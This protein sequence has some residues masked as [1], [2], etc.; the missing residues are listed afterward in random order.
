MKSP[1]FEELTERDTELIENLFP[2]YLFYDTLLNGDREF[3]CSHCRQR[4]IKSHI[5]RTS[6]YEDREL[7][8]VRHGDLRCCPLCGA[9]T[10]VKN[11][12]KSKQRK[13]LWCREKVVVIHAVNHDRVEARCYFAEKDYEYSPAP[14]TELIEKSRYLL[15]PV[16]DAYFAKLVEEKYDLSPAGI[17]EFLDL[18]NVDYE[19]LAEGCHY[20][21]ELPKRVEERV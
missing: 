17:I 14:K 16:E 18:L 8:H 5:A 1:E 10:T 12:G 3:Q 2:H 13:N 4:F 6:S 21:A 19:R 7:M 20:R 9:V 15:T 11:L